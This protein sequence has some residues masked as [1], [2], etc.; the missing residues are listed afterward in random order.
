MKPAAED[1][2]D[3]LLGWM[4]REHVYTTSIIPNYENAAVPY[5]TPGRSLRS[6]HELAAID[7]AREVF[8]D[9]DGRPND[10]WKRFV[11]SVSLLD[12]A[13][14]N[15]NGA[16]PD[17]L[18]A[19]GQFDETQQRNIGDYLRGA[20]M[21][22]STGPGYFQNANDAQ[23]VAGSTGDTGGF[24]ATIS[25]LRI[26][27][28]V[29][30]GR[31]E[32]R[33]STVIAPASGGATPVQKTASETRTETSARSAQTA[34]KQ[35]NQPNAPQANM[36]PG[37]ANPANPKQPSAPAAA[38]KYPFTLLEIRENDEISSVAPPAP[39]AGGG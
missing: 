38:L 36:R 8:Y 23:R 29:R 20:G 6:Y 34:A 18:A 10:L 14:P 37:A 28:L 2:A 4:K 24:G 39:L 11:A 13:K 26:N 21:F 16:R 25:A 32:Y 12:F 15:I 3:A 30:D 17:T 9:H 31:T 27:V 7:K 35:Q 22:Q 33:L 19:L 5:E 1:L